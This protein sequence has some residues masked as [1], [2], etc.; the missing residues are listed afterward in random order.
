MIARYGADSARMYTLFAAP[1]DRDLDWQDSGVEGVY[2]FLGRVYR[3]IAL[4]PTSRSAGSY[5]AADLSPQ[6]RKLVRK[7]HQTIKKITDDFAG[8]WHFNTSVA[9]LMELSNACV[10][11]AFSEPA[12]KAL[13]ADVQ[14]KFVLMLAPFAPYL[15]HE[16][17]ETLGEGSNMLRASWPKYDPALAK[18]EEIEIPIQVNSRLKGRLVIALDSPSEEVEKRVLADEKVRASL[19]GKQVV[20]VIIVPNKL[21]N[22]VAK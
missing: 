14:R 18:E 22:I 20:K 17:W 7:L 13:L 5:S 21:V 3:F 11:E 2:K 1:P 4:Q 8:R 15:A 6:G 16:L 19:D 10:P 12:G 9:A